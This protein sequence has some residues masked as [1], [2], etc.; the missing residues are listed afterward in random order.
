ML[1]ILRSIIFDCLLT[2]Y[3]PELMYFNHHHS[4]ISIIASP[5][6]YDMEYFLDFE[7][8]TYLIN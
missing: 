8:H 1:G 3:K 2:P 5:S 4:I 7:P 6:K